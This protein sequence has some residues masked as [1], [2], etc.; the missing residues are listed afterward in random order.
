MGLIHR[1]F[2]GYYLLA[3]TQRAFATIEWVAKMLQL[4]RAPAGYAIV[5]LVATA[6]RDKVL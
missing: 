5:A 2:S 4:P 6:L 1:H 3:G